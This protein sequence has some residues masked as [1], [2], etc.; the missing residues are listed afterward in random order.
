MWH[1]LS[2]NVLT[3]STEAMDADDM[4]ASIDN[5]REIVSQGKTQLDKLAAIL[6]VDG[7]DVD[8]IFAKS[9]LLMAGVGDVAAAADIQIAREHFPLFNSLHGALD[10]AISYE[11]ER[12]NKHCEELATLSLDDFIKFKNDSLEFA[13]EANEKRHGSRRWWRAVVGAPKRT[14]WQRIINKLPW[15]S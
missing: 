4:T 5:L 10:E 6:Q 1:E 12:F 3:K 15:R 13:T 2:F 14:V 7:D 8:A 11:M 9:R